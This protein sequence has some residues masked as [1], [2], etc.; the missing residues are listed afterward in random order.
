MV[1]NLLSAC[2]LTFFAGG[3]RL[4]SDLSFSVGAGHLLSIVGDNGSGKTTLLRVLSGLLRPDSGDVLWRG[5]AITRRDGSYY[6]DLIYIGHKNAI[7]HD[8]SP[9]ENLR[10]DVALRSCSP[11]HTAD[12]ALVLAGLDGC[13]TGLCRELSVGQRRRV[14]LSRLL[15]FETPLWLLDEP[16]SGLDDV[17]RDFFSACL[18]SHLH[19]GGIAVIGTPRTDELPGI[20]AFAVRLGEATG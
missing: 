18:R 17:G 16:L 20:S 13:Q 5:R 10:T 14:A 9:L 7:H 11:K 2:G 4:F 3:R 19:K 6:S 12:E 15:V 8:L 1:E